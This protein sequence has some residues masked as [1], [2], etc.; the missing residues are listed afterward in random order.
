[1]IDAA[2][3]DGDIVVIQHQPEVRNG[4]MVAAWLEDEQATTLKYIYHE[5]GKFRLQPANPNYEPITKEPHQVTI[6]GKVVHLIRQ[7]ANS[8]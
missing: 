8:A 7:F 1:M 2:V 4:D 5:A 6:Q 3:L